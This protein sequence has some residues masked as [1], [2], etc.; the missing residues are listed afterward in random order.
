MQFPFLRTLVIGLLS[1]SWLFDGAA[2]ADEVKVA[3]ASNFAAPM[4]KIAAAFESATGHRAILALG[5]TGKLYTQIRHGA[6]FGV[7]LAAD[8]ATPTR[9]AREGAGV[10]DSQFTYAV[11]QLVLWSARPDGV[12]S[13][14]QV[15]RRALP[16]KLAVADPK[17]APYGAAAA[18][19]LDRLGLRDTVQPHLVVGENIGQTFQFVKTENAPLG[20]VALSQ[21]MV[22]GRVAIG[23][24]WVVPGELYTPIRQDAILLQPAAQQPAARAL[25]AFLRSDAARAIIQAYGYR[26]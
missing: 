4:Q 1:G 21:V 25:M 14:G 3:V 12:D 16:G 13:A 26:F 11:G 22:D 15:L 5:S 20:F 19:V 8:D 10:A 24:A 17:L 23:S 9:L 2:R 7:L 18:Q 6:P